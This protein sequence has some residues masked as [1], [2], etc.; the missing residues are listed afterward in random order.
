ML[1]KNGDEMSF[2]NNN[3]IIHRQT[4]LTRQIQRN[5]GQS[6]EDSDLTNYV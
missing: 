2:I 6:D 3:R 4:C 5:N 1:L